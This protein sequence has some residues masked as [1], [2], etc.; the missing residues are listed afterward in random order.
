MHLSE[1]LQGLCYEIVGNPDIEVSSLA[2]STTEV[3]SGCMFFCIKGTQVDG[4]DLFRKAVGDGATVLVVERRLNTAVTQ[5]IVEDVR[6]TMACAAKQFYDNVADKLKIVCVVGTNGK[7]S[8]TYLLDAIFNKAGYNTA[9]IG[10]N[11][12]FING[13]HHDS[14]LTTPDPINLH[15]WLYQAYLNKVHF[16]FMELSAHAI[17]LRK[18][19]GI[20][21]EIIA[22]TNFTQDHLDFFGTMDKYRSTK[23][24]VFCQHF[25]KAAVVNTD[26]SL[27][28]EILAEGQLPTIS[29]GIGSGDV[30]A[31]EVQCSDSGISYL[32][33]LYD[34]KAYVKYSLC[35]KFNVYNTLCATAVAR[36]FGVD[37]DTIVSGIAEVHDI[38]GRNQTVMRDD[39]VRIVVDFAHTPDGIDNILS[40]LKSITHGNLLVVFGCGGN[41]DKFKRPLMAQAVS[42]WAEFAI[43]TNDN[44]R[45]ESPQ[46]IA[47]EVTC[48]LTCPY[49]V[50]LNRSQ[51]TQTALSVAK[52]GDTVAILGKG[53][54]C[55]QEIKGRKYPYSDMDVVMRLISHNE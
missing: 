13:R 2:C 19:Y 31:D 35:G 47:E 15:R 28:Q 10:S 29:Y 5:V 3:K 8:T 32:L 20:K 34:N 42:R 14:Q 55:Y 17:A 50:V 52:A 12:V 26:D 7:T 53:A 51:A 40:Y 6:A 38:D 54:E 49:K 21:A 1:V 46:S 39:G 45:F 37:I 36:V 4:H 33:T 9:V 18:N 25:T 22:F 27:G 30:R 44:P 43:V 24:S 11:G 16:V 48:A 23:K 41:R